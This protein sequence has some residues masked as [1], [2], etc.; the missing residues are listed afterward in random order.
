M[1]VG[2]AI[3]VLAAVLGTRALLGTPPV[4]TLAPEMTMEMPQ[5]SAAAP[6][7]LAGKPI[8]VLQFQDGASRVD[9]VSLDATGIER[10]LVDP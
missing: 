9:E 6:G 5:P 10:H 4:G 8:G 3:F 2:A 7:P 1:A